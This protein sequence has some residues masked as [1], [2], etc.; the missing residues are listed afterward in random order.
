MRFSICNETFKDWSLE[1][2]FSLISKLGYDGIEIAPFTI[3]KDVRNVSREERKIIKELSQ[4]YELKIVGLHWLLVSPKGLHI[5]YP[6]AYEKTKKYIFEL[7][8]F[9]HDIGG[10]VLVFG[11]PKQRNIPKEM[12]YEQAWKNA[13]KFFKDCSNFAKKY[14][15]II[16]LEPL[17]RHLTNFIN[18]SEEAIRMIKDV[19][20]PNFKLILDVYSMSHEEREIGKTIKMSSEYLVHFHANDTNGLGPG[21]GNANYY[22]ISLALKSINYKGYLSVEILRPIKDPIYIAKKSIENLK[23]YFR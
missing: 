13:V 1:K 23:K 3:S 17:A 11:S 8:K 2:V 15:S 4:T 22:E 19:N 18:T 12:S 10:K 6:N 16:A 14:D 5:F 20:S 9:N 7:I 21:L